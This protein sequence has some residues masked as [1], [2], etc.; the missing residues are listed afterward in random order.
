MQ[1]PR[2]VC[3]TLL[4]NFGQWPVSWSATRKGGG[5]SLERYT[6][7]VERT[8]EWAKGVAAK[9]GTAVAWVSTYPPPLNDG[10]GITYRR[11]S[12]QVRGDLTHFP[13]TEHRFP[14]VIARL[15]RVAR[16]A[17][18]RAGVAYI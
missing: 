15:N 14:H 11:G 13:P 10:T 3:K 16:D 5:W 4:I 1:G 7:A 9:Q 2:S 17:A 18:H 12:S 8:L 6:T